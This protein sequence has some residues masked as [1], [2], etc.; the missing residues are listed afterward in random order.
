MTS[1]SISK[2]PPRQPEVVKARLIQAAAGLLSGGAPVSIGSVADAAGVSKGAVQYHFGTREQLFLA[3]FDAYI[4]SFEGALSESECPDEPAALRY[5]RLT[6]KPIDSEEETAWRAVLIASVM[7]RQVASRWSD[8]VAAD[9]ATDRPAS[10]ASL[11]VRL[12][13]DGLW[14]SQLLS[15]YQVSDEERAGVFALMQKIL[16]DEEVGE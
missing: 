5:A 15:V 9:R 11:L 4:G 7:D 16:A 12:A 10:P 2:R 1:D 3:L 6:I 14:F 13:A 8:W